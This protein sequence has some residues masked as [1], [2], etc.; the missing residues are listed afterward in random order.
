MRARPAC[1]TR[2]ARDTRVGQPLR[3]GRPSR[4]Q[5]R[6]T[7][8]TVADVYHRVRPGYPP[9]L[10]DDL[11]AMLPDR[12]RLIEVGPGTGPGDARPPGTRRDR[13]RRRARAGDGDDA[14]PRAAERR[15]H[16]HRRR[17]RARAAS[18]RRPVRRAV[19]G[20]GVPLDRAAPP[21]S[22]RP[23]ELL[24]P[25]GLVAIV[26]LIQVDSDV[27]RGFFD[28]VQP[29]YE[30][31]GE[32]RGGAPPPPRRD[33]VDPP[34]RAQLAGD[35]RFATPTVR[36]YDWDQTYRA[37]EYRELLTSYSGTQTMEPAARDAL[38]RRHG[39]LRRRALRRRGHAADR[40]D[41]H[42]SV[43]R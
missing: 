29:I 2:A 7:F 20:H 10:F 23:A 26:D 38:P 39:A 34:M 12:P 28:A 35:E 1:R 17:L 36:T 27:D 11:F 5:P 18:R 32:G 14:A 8:D 15:P 4:A 43:R 41:P 6:A 40:R 16:D 37:A 3:H 31:Y 33:E 24:A 13:P 9:A 19:L 42:D 30:R 21:R 25:G 22:A